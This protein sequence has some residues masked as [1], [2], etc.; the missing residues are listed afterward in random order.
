L[1]Q[2]KRDQLRKKEE[3]LQLLSSLK[4]F[5][6]ALRREVE[7]FTDEELLEF[8]LKIEPYLMIYSQ[9]TPEM[10][11]GLQDALERERLKVA[12]MQKKMN[13]MNIIL[14]EMHNRLERIEQK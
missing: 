10:T 7:R 4:D 14:E 5:N 1:E 9:Q 2:R 13:Y 12:N 11:K 8:Y 3:A 6:Y